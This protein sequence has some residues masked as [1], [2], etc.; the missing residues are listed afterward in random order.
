MKKLIGVLVLVS[1]LLLLGACGNSPRSLMNNI[2][3]SW[4]R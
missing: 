3:K 4:E 2:K 1:S